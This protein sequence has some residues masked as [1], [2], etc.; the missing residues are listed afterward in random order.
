MNSLIQTSLWD[1]L[2]ELFFLCVFHREAAIMITEWLDSLS[3]NQ[4]VYLFENTEV[5][6]EWLAGG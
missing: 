3:G 1:R 2:L 5:Q 6:K 4:V